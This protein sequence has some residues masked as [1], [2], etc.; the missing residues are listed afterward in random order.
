VAG[1]ATISDSGYAVGFDDTSVNGTSG[2]GVS[3][4]EVGVADPETAG[5]D[6]E[7]VSCRRTMDPIASSGNGAAVNNARKSMIVYTSLRMREKKGLTM[8]ETTEIEWPFGCNTWEGSGKQ[9]L[10]LPPPIT[11]QLYSGL[12]NTF[13]ILA[14]LMSRRFFFRRC[15]YCSRY[16]LFWGRF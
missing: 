14:A 13:N 1:L 6:A 12:G 4:V 9:Q 16:S 5:V 10:N 11:T 3:D 7:A 15:L 2:G 8:A